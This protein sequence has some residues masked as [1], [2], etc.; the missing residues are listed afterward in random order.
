RL[1]DLRVMSVVALVATGA[2][3]WVL[4]RQGLHRE[5]AHRLLALALASPFNNAMVHESWVDVYLIAGVIWWLAWRRTHRRWA[6][7]ALAVALLVKPTSL[8]VLVP[9]FLWSQRARIEVAL[10]A[11]AAAIYALPF[12][13]A[14]GAGDFWYDVIGSQLALPPR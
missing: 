9:A 8:I 3:L 5:H 14:T 10:A 13:V 12:V 4:A 7:V 6:M 1:G 11:V 2:G